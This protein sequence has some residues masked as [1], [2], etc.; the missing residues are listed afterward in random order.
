MSLLAGGATHR[1]A[2]FA[3]RRREIGILTHLIDEGL[4]GRHRL[5]CVEAEPGM[6]RRRLIAEALHRG[7]VNAGVRCADRSMSS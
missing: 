4:W 7:V 5:V 1:G 2:P 3:G 6:G